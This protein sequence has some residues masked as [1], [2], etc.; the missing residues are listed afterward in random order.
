MRRRKS[1][2]CETF[3]DKDIQN[4]NNGFY[5]ETNKPYQDKFIAKYIEPCV[6]ERVRKSHKG[7]VRSRN[8]GET[9][10]FI[11]KRSTQEK[12]RVCKDFFQRVLGGLGRTRIENIA[13]ELRTTGEISDR[14]FHKYE[15]IDAYITL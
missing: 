13:F 8:N 7:T 15:P 12:H 6:K 11:Y 1:F 2:E 5:K 4:F 10:Y 3:D 14:K 9:K